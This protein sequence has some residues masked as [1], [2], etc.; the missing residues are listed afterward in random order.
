MLCGIFFTQKALQV[1]ITMVTCAKNTLRNY[2]VELI[3]NNI[4]EFKNFLIFE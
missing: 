4:S 1:L 3:F 2:F